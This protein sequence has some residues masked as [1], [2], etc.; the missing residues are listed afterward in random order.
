M[1]FEIESH[2]KSL[3]LGLDQIKEDILNSFTQIIIDKSLS[4]KHIFVAGNGGS[5]SIANHF[6]TDL[7]GGFQKT[8]FKIKVS[9]LSSNDSLI[10]EDLKFEISNPLKSRYNGFVGILLRSILISILPE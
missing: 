8:N 6:V 5:A 3:N 9:S 1:K 4:G 7:I 2:I 10:N